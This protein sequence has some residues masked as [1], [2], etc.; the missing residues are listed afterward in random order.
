[1]EQPFSPRHRCH[2]HKCE[3]KEF[4]QRWLQ[5]NDDSPGVVHANTCRPMWQVFT[6]P[7]SHAIGGFES[8]SD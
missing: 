4:C 2:D 8:A 1:M 3:V 6:E 7:C 5:R